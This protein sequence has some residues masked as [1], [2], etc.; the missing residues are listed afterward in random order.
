MLFALLVIL[1]T[2]ELFGCNCIEIGKLKRAGR[3]V[4]NSSATLEQSYA[5]YGS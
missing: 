1:F 4:W 2:N 3:V 5:F